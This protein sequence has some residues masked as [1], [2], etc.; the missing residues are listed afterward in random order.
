[1]GS[2]M[3]VVAEFISIN[4][5]GVQMTDTCKLARLSIYPICEKLCSGERCIGC[6][7]ILAELATDFLP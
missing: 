2:E 5:L 1:M 4:A 3:T 7:S 6:L